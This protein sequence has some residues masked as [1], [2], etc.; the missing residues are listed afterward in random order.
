MKAA[1]YQREPARQRMGC[2]MRVKPGRKADDPKPD[3]ERNAGLGRAMDRV[4]ARTK[5]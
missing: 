3:A 5:R 2:I 1:V 4:L